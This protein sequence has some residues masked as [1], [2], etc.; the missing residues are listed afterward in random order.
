[1]SPRRTSAGPAEAGRYGP[2]SAGGEPSRDPGVPREGRPGD[3]VARGCGMPAG[4][5]G[6]RPR[7]GGITANATRMDGSFRVFTLHDAPSGIVDCG[8]SRSYGACETTVV[9]H[10][11][12]D[13]TVGL[14]E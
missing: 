1:R 11:P 14:R 2:P 8:W 9:A 4:V 10:E 7:L 3:G 5:P 13:Q 12:P 6:D